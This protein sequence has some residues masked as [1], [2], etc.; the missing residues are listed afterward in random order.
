MITGVHI[1]SSEMVIKNVD[2]KKASLPQFTKNQVIKAKVLGFLPNGK[3]QLLVNGK[4]ISAKTTMLLTPGEEVQ[5]K[6]VQEKDAI[7][8]KLIGP[9]QKMTTSQISSLI[10]F[11]SKNEGIP[12][13]SQNRLSQVNALLTQI[14]LKSDQADDDFLPRLIEKSG[15]VME[16]KMAQILLSDKPLSQI[17]A[18][19]NQLFDQDIKANIL[20]ELSNAGPGRMETLKTVAA[21]SE[22]LENFQLLN[23]SSSE[24]GRVLL[25]FPI[26]SESSFRFGQLLID[27]GENKEDKTGKDNDRV[28]NISFLLDMTRLGPLRADFSILKQEISGRFIFC[29]DDTCDYVKTLIP[30]LKVQLNERQYQVRQIE[31]CVAKQ[32]D[33]QPSS[34]IETLVKASDDRVLNI[35]V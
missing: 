35:V 27:T 34:L 9:I 10:G 18:N 24:S 32:E 11:F 15:L 25:P 29:D 17:K 1:S 22:T 23:H 31:C 16:K 33:I 19:L 26:F 20:K 4:T 6:V 13:I 3:A 7:I 14:A 12:D 21:F 30:A 5:L 8:L 28:I 2:G